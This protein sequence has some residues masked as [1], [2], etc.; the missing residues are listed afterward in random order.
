MNP[1]K[2]FAG[3]QTDNIKLEE[4]SEMRKFKVPRDRKMNCFFLTAFFNLVGDKVGGQTLIRTVNGSIRW[5]KLAV[6]VAC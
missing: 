2:N 6:S 5:F 4:E 1:R 3:G